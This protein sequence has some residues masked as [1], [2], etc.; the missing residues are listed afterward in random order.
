MTQANTEQGQPVVITE[1]LGEEEQWRVKGWPNPFGTDGPEMEI[2]PDTGK[3][4]DVT[5][6]GKGL[7]V[8]EAEAEDIE[9]DTPEPEGG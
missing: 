8:P 1:D 7:A 4:Q 6:F 3:Y 5:T 2:N 9:D